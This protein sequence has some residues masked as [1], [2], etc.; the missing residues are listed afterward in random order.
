MTVS[1]DR[2]RGLGGKPTGPS[3]RPRVS[4]T[5]AGACV[6][7]LGS[8]T[9]DCER[10]GFRT[11][12]RAERQWGP[13]AESLRLTEETDEEWAGEG[14]DHQRTTKPFSVHLRP[15]LSKQL[16]TR[17]SLA[18]ARASWDGLELQPEPHPQTKEGAGARSLPILG[19][20]GGLRGYASARTPALGGPVTSAPEPRGATVGGTE[21]SRWALLSE[22]QLSEPDPVCLS[23]PRP[24]TPLREEVT[25]PTSPNETGQGLEETMLWTAEAGGSSRSPPFR[26]Q[27]FCGAPDPKVWANG[28]GLKVTQKV[29]RVSQSS[30]ELFGRNQRQAAPTC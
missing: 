21:T 18:G 19:S 5:R 24:A 12:D 3:G 29:P 7:V 26:P 4:K 14:H 1:S 17:R 9:E 10:A 11:Q 6:P 22:C 20:A 2:G 27:F 15:L 25:V 16:H 28:L 13:P 23:H 8:A 30:H